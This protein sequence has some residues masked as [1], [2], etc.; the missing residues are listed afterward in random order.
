MRVFFNQEVTVERLAD[1]S[2]R[3]SYAA[4]GTIEAGIFSISADDLVLSE[5]N[6]AK[7]SI[8]YCEADADIK[9]TDRV[10]DEDSTAYIV[11][12]VKTPKKIFTLGYR[13]CIIEEMNS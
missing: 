13:R 10:T 2:D 8:L 6:L 4:H 1:A 9:P 3:E 12:A 7:S 5:G 11:K